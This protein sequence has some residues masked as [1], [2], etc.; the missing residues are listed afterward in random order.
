MRF[1]AVLSD[2]LTNPCR[3]QRHYRTHRSYLTSEGSGP[4]LGHTRAR[5]RDDLKALTVDS[6]SSEGPDQCIRISTLSQAAHTDLPSWSCGFDSR[7]PRSV[8]RSPWRL[9]HGSRPWQR[10]PRR[11]SFI[12]NFDLDPVRIFEI[13]S[14]VAWRVIWVCFSAT[15]EC[16]N[17]TWLQKVVDE[18]INHV[19]RANLE[20]YVA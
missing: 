4:S 8:A 18:R 3:G 19:S 11:S 13:D 6:G 5:C 14:I 10:P 7:R 9:A 2:V 16:F 15:I 20:S 1:K 17:L 12:V